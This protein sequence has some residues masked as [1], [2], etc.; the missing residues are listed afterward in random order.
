MIEPHTAHLRGF[1]CRT[2]AGG[3]A[4]D[5]LED[6]EIGQRFSGCVQ[7]A[8][9]SQALQDDLAADRIEKA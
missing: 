3:D 8:A 4:A 9:E 1:G 2:A 5:G 6:S 7:H